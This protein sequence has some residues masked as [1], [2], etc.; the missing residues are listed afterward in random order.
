VLTAF[1][2]GAGVMKERDRVVKMKDGWTFPI[3]RVVMLVMWEWQVLMYSRVMVSTQTCRVVS[4][5][6]TEL[7]RRL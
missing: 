2:V 5:Q 1:W 3:V 4:L 6:H 7:L